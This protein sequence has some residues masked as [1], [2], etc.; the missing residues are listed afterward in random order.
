MAW[1]KEL[2]EYIDTTFDQL[3]ELRKGKEESVKIPVDLYCACLMVARPNQKCDILE[4]FVE[5]SRTDVINM[6]TE[7]HTILHGLD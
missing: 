2:V 7:A 1:D 6:V 3:D 4:E 5:M